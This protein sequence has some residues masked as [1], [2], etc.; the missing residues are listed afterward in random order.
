[1]ANVGL[2]QGSSASCILFIVYVDKMIKMVKTSFQADG[3][4]GMLHILMFMD[5]TIL[6]ATS[7]EKLIEKRRRRAKLRFTAR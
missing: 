1:M 4:L 6:L 2:K 3:F 5:D 7:R